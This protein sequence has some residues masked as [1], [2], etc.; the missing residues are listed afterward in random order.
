[1]PVSAKGRLENQNWNPTAISQWPV[2]LI[3]AVQLDSLSRLGSLPA[4][5]E[6]YVDLQGVHFTFYVLRFSWKNM[7]VSNFLRFI[8][9]GRCE[10]YPVGVQLFLLKFYP[11]MGDT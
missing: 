8:T 7:K 9:E 2:G 5:G 6:N 1:M 3:F 11:P 4:D 10:A